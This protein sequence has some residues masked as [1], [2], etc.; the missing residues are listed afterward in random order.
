MKEQSMSGIKP[1]ATVMEMRTLR[2]AMEK[3]GKT[4]GFVPTMGA[5]HAGHASLIKAS[6]SACDRTVVSIFV[7][8]TQFGPAEDLSKYPRP[9]A[10]DLALAEASG[11]SAVFA[12]SD[13]E[14][15]PPGCST[16][17]DVQGPSQGLCGAS[18]P[19]HFRGVTTVVAKLFNIVKP[20][21]AYFGKKDAQQAAVI[22][23]MVRDLDMDLEIVVCPTVREK[24][25]LALSS[26]NVYLG[27]KERKAATSLSASLKAA[28][29]SARNGEKDAAVLKTLI[30]DAITGKAERLARIDYVEIVDGETML[31]VEKVDKPSLA[32]IAVF[33]GSTRLIDNADIG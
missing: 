9:L 3:D 28:A 30:R 19:G 31:P 26:R 1:V 11:A 27:E 23:K 32:V 14:M 18:R 16:W 5:L 12:P 33:I 29:E 24:D 25:G 7:N 17:V 2:A 4:V 6:A 22:R 21:R 13:A 10:K 20:H 8:P 15:Y